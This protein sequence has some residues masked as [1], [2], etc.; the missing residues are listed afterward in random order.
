MTIAPPGAAVRMSGAQAL[1]E[2]LQREGVDIVFGYPGGA[3][4]SPLRCAL[5]FTDSAYPRAPRAGRR[6]C[7]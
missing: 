3:D 7:G 6:A 5:R 4:S 2:S 1:L